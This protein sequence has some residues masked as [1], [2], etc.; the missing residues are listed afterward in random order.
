MADISWSD[1]TAIAPEMSTVSSGAQTMILA[2]VNN[3]LN[4]SEFGG[5]SA[6]TLKL[7]RVYLAAHRGAASLGGGG[8]GPIT[9]ESMGGLSRSY[10]AGVTTDRLDSSPYGREYLSLVNM[11]SA[12]SPIV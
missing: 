6:P 4:V 5:E 12:R 7:A 10:G 3:V 2:Y 11:S 9:S 8:A 1:V